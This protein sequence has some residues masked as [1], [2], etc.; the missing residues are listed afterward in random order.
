MVSDQEQAEVVVDFIQDV[1]TILR[2]GG[3]WVMGVDR[4]KSRDW[5]LSVQNSQLV[6]ESGEETILLKVVPSVL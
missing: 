3:E 1:A 4:E 2:D 5:V 6:A